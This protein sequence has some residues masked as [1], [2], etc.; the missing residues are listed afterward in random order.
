MTVNV[1]LLFYS[2]YEGNSFFMLVILYQIIWRHVPVFLGVGE[3][4]TDFLREQGLEHFFHI[5][6]K[7]S[8]CLSNKAVGCE[9]IGEWMCRARFYDSILAGGD[10]LP[11]HPDHLTH[12]KGALVCIE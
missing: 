9:D 11:S 12:M 2:E 5:K 7:L 3:I 10:W 1:K 6:V 8:L 4:C